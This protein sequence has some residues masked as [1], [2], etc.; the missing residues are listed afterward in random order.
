MTDIQPIVDALSKAIGPALE[1]RD[2]S[3]AARIRA[4]AAEAWGVKVTALEDEL[5]RCKGSL[6][7]SNAR[8]AALSLE[9]E[10]AKS[11]IR[12]LTQA[13]PPVIVEPPI[14]DPPTPP[15]SDDG[16][17][18]I[19]AHDYVGRTAEQNLTIPR[20][21]WLR[22]NRAPRTT[23]VGTFIYKANE[24]AKLEN[25]DIKALW[26]SCI[27][28]SSDYPAHRQGPVVIRNVGH[29]MQPG[30]TQRTM[31]G[32]R[33]W[34]MSDIDRSDCDFTGLQEHGTYDNPSGATS[35][36]RNTYTELGGH[37]VYICLRNQPT[38]K[39][40]GKTWQY[41][42]NNAAPTG[43][44][45]HVIEDIH[46]R[47]VCY[48]A[49]K[50]SDTLTFF[51]AGTLEH[52]AS[53][54]IRDCTDIQCF[55]EQIHTG[56]GALLPVGATGSREYVRSFAAVTVKTY[57]DQT[58]TGITG[59]HTHPNKILSFANCLW[60]FTQ[61]NKELMNLNDCE[62]IAFDGCT[63]IARNHRQPVVKIDAQPGHA[64]TNEVVIANCASEGV[65]LHWTMPNG[66]IFQ[67]TLDTRGRFMRL[68]R[69]Q[70]TVSVE[71]IQYDPAYRV[72][73][74]ESASA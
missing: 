31:W 32:E 6:G 54:Y 37:S 45:T 19:N 3:V 12:Q 48:S 28:F 60:D 18:I 7:S 73:Q 55:P 36:R 40:D 13:G 65:T 74:M 46:S 62:K 56:T 69:F 70:S 17:A 11:I 52:Q 38:L 25:L 22:A 9:L 41:P 68:S 29:S 26:A 24:V 57:A 10:R 72:T 44:T 15:A 16:S 33:N 5:A 67:H 64:P 71:N 8:V 20:F 59:P 23:K 47:N 1:A 58:P 21:D 35:N 43:P 30:A 53:I 66:T 50:G 34:S 42:P 39:E 2:A 14:V 63:F 27:G 49:A 4:S 51:N 61:S